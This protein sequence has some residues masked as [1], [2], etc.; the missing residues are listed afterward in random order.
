MGPKVFE[1]QGSIAMRSSVDCRPLLANLLDG[2]Q[3]RGRALLISGLLGFRQIALDLDVVLLYRS[4]CTAALDDELF[5]KS[6]HLCN[7][8][9]LLGGQIR[10]FTD[11]IGQIVELDGLR[12]VATLA[13]ASRARGGNVQPLAEAHGRGTEEGGADGMRS[14]G[15]L[16]AFK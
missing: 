15:I 3:C 2:A 1:R 16:P 4:W 10:G 5:E 12:L 7:P 9:R 13:P 14:N 11:V 8:F 6:L